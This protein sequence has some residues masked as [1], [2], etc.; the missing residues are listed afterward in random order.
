MCPSSLAVFA[1]YILLTLWLQ[2]W[3]HKNRFSHVNHNGLGGKKKTHFVKVKN[4]L[5]QPLTM[6]FNCCAFRN[7]N[8]FVEQKKWSSVLL[9]LGCRNSVCPVPHQKP[10]QNNFP[11]NSPPLGVS[12]TAPSG[13]SGA[14][15]WPRPT[16]KSHWP[17]DNHPDPTR[18][19]C[20]ND[21]IS[22]QAT[23]TPDVHWRT[24]S[25]RRNPDFSL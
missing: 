18:T 6:H 4:V 19:E 20:F 14:E 8:E 22:V 25:N 2:V 11:H 21:N 24:Y 15:L 9:I 5:D 12:Y 3:R 17:R 13:D 10:K 7:V 1:F 23:L 16:W